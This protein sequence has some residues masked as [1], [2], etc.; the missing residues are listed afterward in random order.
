[1]AVLLA[2]VLDV[3]ATRLEDPQAEQPEHGDGGEVVDVGAGATGL[4]HRL[5]LQVRQAQSG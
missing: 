3:R 2:Q 5:E 1:V 4:Q